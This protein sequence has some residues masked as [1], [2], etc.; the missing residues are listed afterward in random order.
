[1]GW[2]NAAKV[3]WAFGYVV[4]EL[5]WNSYIGFQVV[6]SFLAVLPSNQLHL[7]CPQ[8][9]SVPNFYV[10]DDL[11]LAVACLLAFNRGWDGVAVL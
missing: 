3:G 9:T 2:P 6:E 4:Q 10:S 11:P 7:R 8:L 5:S 1:M